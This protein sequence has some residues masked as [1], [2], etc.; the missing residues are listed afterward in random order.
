MNLLTLLLIPLATTF[1]SAAAPAK[2]NPP[3]A[4]ETLWRQWYLFT[5]AGVPQGYYEETVERRPAEKHL[6]VSQRWVEKEGGRTETFIGSVAFDTP[7]L[8]PV[9]FFSERTGAA[10]SYKL[11][12]RAKGAKLELTYKPVQPP[13]ANIR[14]SALLKPTTVLSNFVPIL[15]SRRALSP[16][17]FQFEAVVED[18]RDGNFDVRPGAAEVLGVNKQIGGQTCRKAI[19]D[20]AGEQAEWW[21]TKEG[22][23][24]ELTIHGSQAKLVMTTE[25]EAKKALGL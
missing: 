17:A 2:K 19:V 9:A 25:A 3:P 10:K 18:A 13:G 15:L 11:D 4:N 14:K 16:G 12:G 5:A 23:L 1:A 20:F 21:I 6:A 7:K 8:A 22:R 24:C